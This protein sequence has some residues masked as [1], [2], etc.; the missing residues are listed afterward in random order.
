MGE[1]LTQLVPHNS[2]VKVVLSSS[3]NGLPD[4]YRTC[5]CGSNGQFHQCSKSS[6]C[7][8]QLNQTSQCL[9]KPGMIFSKS[10]RST[11]L[12]NLLFCYL[13]KRLDLHYK[14]ISLTYKSHQYLSIYLFTNQALLSANYTITRGQLNIVQYNHF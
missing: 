11:F 6:V 3:A 5:R 8:N 1:A 12:L 4:C 9:Y 7:A 13:T 10:T 14:I 2:Y